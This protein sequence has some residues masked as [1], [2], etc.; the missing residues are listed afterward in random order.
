MLE[1]ITTLSGP[2]IGKVHHGVAVFKGIPY[3]APPVGDL[4]FAPPEPPEPWSKPF[5][6][7]NFGPIAPQ[8]FKANDLMSHPS[9]SYT[10]SEDCL[11]LN[12]WTPDYAL[13]SSKLPVFV[14]VHGGGFSAG[15]AGQPLY[16]RFANFSPQPLYDGTTLAKLGIVVVTINYRLGILGFLATQETYQKYG[17]TGNW[18]ILDQVLALI[19]VRDNISAFGGDPEK[20]TLGG[21][22]AGSISAS[23][24][25]VSPIAKG[26][27]NKA[28]LQSGTVLS[29]TQFP[30][31]RGSLEKACRIS[32]S[33][34]DFLELTD[35]PS[36]LK[37]LREV[38]FKILGRLSALSM[39]FRNISPFALS[40]V[41]DDYV[42]PKDPIAKL[43]KGEIN[44]VKVL[45]GFNQDE[46]NLFL[47]KEKDP[48]VIDSIYQA[49]LGAEGTQIFKTHFPVD[50][51]NSPI[52]R[53]RQALS[54]AA[55][56]APTKRF[57]DFASLW[58]DVFLYRFNFVTPLARVMGLGAHHA[59]ELPFVFGTLPL[60]GVVWGQGS[61]YLAE[62]MQSRWASFIAT[63]NPNPKDKI[64]SNEVWPNYFAKYPNVIL[65]E[66]KIKAMPLPLKNSLEFMAQVFFG[67]LEL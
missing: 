62:F 47:P 56:Q 20:V 10:M 30:V 16:G 48:M 13:P 35:S 12:I 18:G 26:L 22:S 64:V 63:G 15:S 31:A 1:H 23:A 61:Q 39:D 25:I 28:I 44:R 45:L 7:L 5:N 49:F 19:W 55:F 27:F 4:R 36:G 52:A 6:A 37:A 51:R 32:E 9:G 41:L 67:E 11:R 2:V 40:P 8:Y 65:L 24:L 29:I 66:K 14:F 50:E 53:V 60:G 21:E 42:I 38:D 3:G 59:A 58:E 46:G 54:L 57:A 33:I 17:T 34:L 43:T